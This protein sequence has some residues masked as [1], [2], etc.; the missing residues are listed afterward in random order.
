VNERKKNLVFF[1]KMWY[2]K[3]SRKFPALRSRAVD[4]NDFR[5]ERGT[6]MKTST[7]VA[8]ILATGAV[9]LATLAMI[10]RKKKKASPTECGCDLDHTDAC[11]CVD[12]DDLDDL[13]E[14]DIY[15]CSAPDDEDDDDIPVVD[16]SKAGEAPD[17][18]EAK[19]EDAE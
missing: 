6:F 12:N 17:P 13:D 18:A 10:S 9:V 2:N 15:N 14:D 11:C 5:R 8:I 4:K 1:K 7:I 19:S 3:N 16:Y